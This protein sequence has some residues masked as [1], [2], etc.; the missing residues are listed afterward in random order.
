[1]LCAVCLLLLFRWVVVLFVDSVRNYITKFINDDWLLENDLIN[2]DEYDKKHFE[3]SK[4]YGNENLIKELE[5]NPVKPVFNDT[6]IK[7]VIKQ[8]EENNLE[9]VNFN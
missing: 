8:L 4:L 2:Q 7:D 1:M 9:C 3:N 6:L 5:L